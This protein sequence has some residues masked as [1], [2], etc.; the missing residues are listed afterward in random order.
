[1]VGQMCA[2]VSS[3]LSNIYT[4]SPCFSPLLLLQ[5]LWYE[6][7]KRHLFPNWMKPGDSE[8]PPMLVYKW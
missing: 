6:A 1:M 4:P 8:P 7:D 3:T 2:C 5:Y